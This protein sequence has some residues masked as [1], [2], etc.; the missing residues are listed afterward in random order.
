MGICVNFEITKESYP[1]IVV[2]Y[3]NDRKKYYQKREQ[4]IL[5][6]NWAQAAHCVMHLEEQEWPDED[7]V[8]LLKASD[9]SVEEAK[10]KLHPRV[11]GFLD[12]VVKQ[13]GSAQ[14]N[15]QTVLLRM[16]PAT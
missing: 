16:V 4:Q 14:A 15:C 13:F 10:K 3:R 9:E 5:A 11:R 12:K 2:D 6:S 1:Q 8:L 7:G